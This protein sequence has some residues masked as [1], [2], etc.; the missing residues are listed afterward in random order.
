MNIEIFMKIK[1]LILTAII[2]FLTACQSQDLS[3]TFDREIEDAEQLEGIKGDIMINILTSRYDGFKRGEKKTRTI[4]DFRL[5]PFV[6]NGDTVLYVAQYADGWEIYSASYAANM[7]LFSS[8]KGI[9]DINDPEMPSQLKTLI[10]GNAQL[11]GELNRDSVNV[12]NPSWKS[13]ALSSQLGENG[14][15]LSVNEDGL[16]SRINPDDVPP[17]YWQ[18]V[19]SKTIS[20]II[21]TYAKLTETVWDQRAPWNQYSKKVVDKSGNRISAPAG[22]GAVALAQYLYYTHF[23]DGVP[24][25]APTSAVLNAKGDD[26]I[27]T[28]ESG[29]IWQEMASKR[30]QEGTEKSALLIGKVGHDLQTKYEPEGSGISDSEIVKYLSR[31][32]GSNYKMKDFDLNIVLELLKKGYPVISGANSTIRNGQSA[33]LE[34]HLFLVDQYKMESTKRC[35]KYVRIRYPL[36][37]GT[38]DKWMADQTDEQGNIIRYAY[39]KEEIVEDIDYY[40]SM[41]WGNVNGA[42]DHVFY[43]PYSSIWNMGNYDFNL[44]HRIYVESN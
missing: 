44:K 9:F 11:I 32:Y 5:T 24:T 1:Y 21:S 39:T 25:Y 35:Y 33:P 29:A 43:S 17:G 41:N 8:E 6:I 42:Y 27:F 13:V 16:L 22:C 23:K 40:I 19:E 34:G 12:I 4:N 18:L 26:Y 7:L 36:P 20:N 2:G 31:V 10:L 30:G 3:D 14:V 28:G 37:A 38:V 15:I